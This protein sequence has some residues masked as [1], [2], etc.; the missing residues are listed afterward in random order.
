MVTLDKG[1]QGAYSGAMTTEISEAT[2][3]FF[4]QHAGYS[5]NPA[6]ETPEEGRR[7]CARDLAEAEAIARLRGWEV[8][9][10][11]DWSIDHETEFDCYD[12]GGPETCETALL[13]DAQ[14]NVLASLGCV[15]DAT[16]EY[17]RVIEAE[18]ADEAVYQSRR[19]AKR[20]CAGF[21]GLR[22]GVR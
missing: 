10:A 1:A 13:V 15:D 21:R 16:D 22:A 7:R 8:R 17:R 14:G 20:L 5:Y 11:D 9:W 18:L 2:I 4:I 6:T 19:E 3:D 12:K